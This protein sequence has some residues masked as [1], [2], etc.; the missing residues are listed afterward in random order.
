MLFIAAS[1]VGTV[2]GTATIVLSQDNSNTPE[3]FDKL[4]KKIEN[5]STDF[6]NVSGLTETLNATLASS[7]TSG[8]PQLL[9]SV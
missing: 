5:D 3:S 9:V 7:H 2:K 1:C 6:D 8:N 4:F